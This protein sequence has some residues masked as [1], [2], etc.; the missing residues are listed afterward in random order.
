MSN[1]LVL[2]V[3]LAYMRLCKEKNAEYMH[4]WK[5]ARGHVYI[6]DFILL[7][8]GYSLFCPTNLLV[9]AK[10]STC[11]TVVDFL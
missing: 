9:Y 2:T 5:E 4:P 1:C 6:V 10:R 8:L 11:I 3:K 7:R